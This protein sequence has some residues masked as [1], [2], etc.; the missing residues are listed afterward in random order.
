VVA[1]LPD[2]CWRNSDDL[3]HQQVAGSNGAILNLLIP[4]ISA[5]LAS[6]MLKERITALRIASLTIGL[7]GCS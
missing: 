2:R 1:V 7:L 5:V 3:G 4:V 6:L